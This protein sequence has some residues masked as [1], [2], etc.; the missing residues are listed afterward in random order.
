MQESKKITIVRN[1]VFILSIMIYHEYFKVI[2]LHPRSQTKRTSILKYATAVFIECIKHL[3]YLFFSY[4]FNIED[5]LEH[6]TISSNIG[7]EDMIC[8]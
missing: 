6:V 2:N 8:E 4:L 3:L 1:L 7:I 5:Y